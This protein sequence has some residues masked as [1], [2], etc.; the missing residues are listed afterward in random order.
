MCA[1]DQDG[2][3]SGTGIRPSSHSMT[4]PRAHISLGGPRNRQFSVNSGGKY[5]G[6]PPLGSG[7]PVTKL[8]PKSIK[9]AP[10]VGLYNML[11]SLMSLCTMLLPCTKQSAEVISARILCAS[12]ILAL[13]RSLPRARRCMSDLA[14]IYS[15]YIH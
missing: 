10:R 15:V 9:T 7:W 6:V 1:I 2:V 11:A 3:V 12:E 8:R 13:E 14:S 4:T 5:H